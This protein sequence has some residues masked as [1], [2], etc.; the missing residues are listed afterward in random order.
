M[1]KTASITDV[2]K[3][4]DGSTDY[5]RTR[6]LS[7]LIPLLAIATFDKQTVDSIPSLDV[8][9]YLTDLGRERGAEFDSIAHLGSWHHDRVLFSIVPPH[10]LRRILTRVF[11]EEEFLSPYGIRSPLQGLRKNALQLPTRRRLRHDQ[12]QPC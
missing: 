6:S 3:R 11:D 5:L 2:L 9:R 4:P 10:R 8:S 7:G 1:S 12:L